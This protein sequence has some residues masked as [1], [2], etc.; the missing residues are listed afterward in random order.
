MKQ[1]FTYKSLLIVFFIALFTSCDNTDNPYLPS[2]PDI[3]SNFNQMYPNAQDVDWSKKGNYYVADCRVNGVGLDVWFNANAV[4][5][6][7]EEELFRSQLPTAVADAFDSSS[8]GNWVIDNLTLLTFPTQ[9]NKI[10]L[11]EVQSGDKEHALG[12][13]ES[14]QLA[15]EKEITNADDTIW[16]DIIQI[17]G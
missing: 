6:M 10:Y 4:W 16:P 7:T 3:V 2:N 17:L 12:Y 15:F 8:Y 9:P 11:F 14:G 5:I 1:L 13:S